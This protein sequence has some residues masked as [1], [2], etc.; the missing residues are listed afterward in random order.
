MLAAVWELGDNSFIPPQK[1]AQ[2]SSPE[3]PTFTLKF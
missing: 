2:A 3:R 1:N